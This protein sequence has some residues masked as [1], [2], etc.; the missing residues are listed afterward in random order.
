MAQH[1]DCIM[2]LVKFS[3]IQLVSCPGIVAPLQG[4]GLSHFGAFQLDDRDA[5]L[6]LI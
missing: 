5:A 1:A 2:Y 4:G 3:V 6:T